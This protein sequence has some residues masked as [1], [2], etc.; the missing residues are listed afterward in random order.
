M[1]AF[2]IAIALAAAAVGL[3]AQESHPVEPARIFVSDVNSR[4]VPLT[5]LSGRARRAA[6]DSG[7]ESPRWGTYRSYASKGYS[8]MPELAK[9]FVNTCPNL[10]VVTVDE[11]KADYLL[12]VNHEADRKPLRHNKSVLVNRQGDV[13]WGDS[14]F[15][16]DTAVKDACGFFQSLQGSR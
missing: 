3:F 1:K 4:S 8:Q 6:N 12:I 2:A 10:A 11:E 13:V 16:V 9:A 7:D 14:T 5:P 15:K